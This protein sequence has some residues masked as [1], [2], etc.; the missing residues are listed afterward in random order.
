MA[1]G[2]VDDVVVAVHGVQLVRGGAELTVSATRQGRQ[3][4]RDGSAVIALHTESGK[5]LPILK[6]ART[7]Q[8]IEHL[9]EVPASRL[10]RQLGRL[11][12]V[13]VGAAHLVASADLANQLAGVHAK[14]DTLLANSRCDQVAPLERILRNARELS[15]RPLDGQARAELWRL[16]GELRELRAGWRHEL[17]DRLARIDGPSSLPRL[18][19]LMTSKQAAD[20]KLMEGIS[21]GQAKVALLDYSM[22]L[23]YVLAVGERYGGVS[24]RRSSLTGA[25]PKSFSYTAPKA[26]EAAPS[27]TACPRARGSVV[28]CSRR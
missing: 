15:R 28:S 9:K 1:R 23:E 17:R 20:M 19:Q 21:E 12:T 10:T 26:M 7:G 11:S 27:W 8:I 25:S 16:R 6:D 5:R 2:L 13:A 24:G 22:R 18:K 14:L 3:L 4:L